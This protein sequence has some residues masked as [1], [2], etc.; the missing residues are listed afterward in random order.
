MPETFDLP[1][2]VGDPA[3]MRALAAALGNDAESAGFVAADTAA[4]IDALEFFGPA[5][6]R[7]DASV[8]GLSRTAGG[9]AQRLLEVSVLLQRAASDV[10]AQQAD[11]ARQLERLRAGAAHAVAA[12]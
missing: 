3:G 2:V 7:I 11:R 9:L 4:M 12:G 1:A 6:G 10:E 8:H 5:A